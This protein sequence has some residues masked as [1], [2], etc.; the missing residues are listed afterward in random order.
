M[1]SKPTP[2]EKA[3]RVAGNIMATKHIV[4]ARE[5]L[6]VKTELCE[7]EVAFHDDADNDIEI[8]KR[9]W[10]AR[11]AYRTWLAGQEK[12]DGE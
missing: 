10:S 4:A 6:R 8:D 3:L 11:D 1:A 12:N 5:E 7:A 9:L 2:L